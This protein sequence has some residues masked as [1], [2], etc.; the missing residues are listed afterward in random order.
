MPDSIGLSQMA[1]PWETSAQIIKQIVMIRTLA[2]QYP[3]V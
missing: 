1:K 3:L 2:A